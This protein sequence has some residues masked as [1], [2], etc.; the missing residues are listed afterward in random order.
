MS[1]LHK[2]LHSAVIISPNRKRSSSNLVSYRG[3]KKGGYLH[4]NW[5]NGII[6]VDSQ[7]LV[8]LER[9]HHDEQPTYM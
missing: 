6:L 3:V 9:N 7:H 4:R 2:K 8:M 1:T 5:D